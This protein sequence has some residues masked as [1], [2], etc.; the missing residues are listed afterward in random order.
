[1][2]INEGLEDLSEGSVVRT[3]NGRFVILEQSLGGGVWGCDMLEDSNGFPDIDGDPA[4]Y[5]PR[6][7]AADLSACER[8]SSPM[9]AAQV[10]QIRVGQR[11]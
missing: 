1:M 10:E 4:C 7:S 3:P 2:H 8:V 9:P 6:L 11:R 5:A